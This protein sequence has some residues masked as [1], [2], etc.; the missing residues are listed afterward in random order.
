LT[1]RATYASIVETS[2]IWLVILGVLYLTSLYSYLLFHSIIEI[3]TIAV[4]VTTFMIAWNARQ[5]M[6]N[7]YL[8]FLGIAYLFV[9]F[10]DLAHTLTY[11][12]MGVFADQT[13]NL[14]TQLWVA[15]RYVQSISLLIAPLF[16]KRKLRINLS[17]V[18]FSLIDILLLLSIFVWDIFPNAYLPATGLTVFKKISEV[19]VIVF[20]LGSIAILVR[21]RKAFAPEVL[22][23]LVLSIATLVLSEVCFTSY[24]SVYSFFNLLG[25]MFRLVAYYLF[26]K[27]IIETGLERPYQLLFWNLK[28]AMKSWMHSH[29]RWRTICK[30]H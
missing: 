29:T 18:T 2:L 26:Y 10:I 21:T 25:H 1:K 22:R 5:M 30:T 19:V 20:L 11:G 23:T 9:A 15:G 6:D 24:A 17:L 13:S 4:A 16:L 27:A 14:P 28:N 12:G 8:L 3:F 7:N